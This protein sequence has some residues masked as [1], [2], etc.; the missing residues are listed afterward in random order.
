MK[1]IF[2]DKVKLKTMSYQDVKAYVTH[3]LTFRVMI[4]R[5]CEVCISPNDPFEHYKRHHTAKK[6]HYVPMKARHK[7][8]EYMTTL[9][10]CQPT[11]VNCPDTW[12]PELKI[13]KDGFKCKFP[14]C[15]GCATSEQSMRQHYYVHQK[16]ILKDFKNWERTALQ[17]FFD[18]RHKK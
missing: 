12:V 13:I 6:D 7:I 1:K 8:A 2:T 10:L 11:E 16:Q 9:D 18:G 3:L 15:N 5:F 17:T 14:E 4:C